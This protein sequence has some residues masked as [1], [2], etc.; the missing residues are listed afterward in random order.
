[1]SGT[2]KQ[3]IGIIGGMG[4]EAMVDLIEKMVSIPGADAREFIAFGNARLAY[5]PEEVMHKW[6]P[7]DPPELRKVDTAAFTLRLMQ[8]LGA[9]VMG[10]ACNSAHALFR[11]QLPA[12]PVAF[13]DMIHQT[14]HSLIGTLDNVLVMGVNS[15]VDSGLYQSALEAQGIASTKPSPD[16]QQKVMSA[17][18]DSAFGIK[19]AQI[20]RE[21][22]VLLCDVIRDECQQQGCSKVVLGCTE[23]PLALTAASCERFK[24]EGL[25]PEHIEVIDASRVLAESLLTAQGEGESLASDLETYRGPHSDW[26][27]PLTFK[28]SSFDMA[29][30]IQNEVLR[31]TVDFLAARGQ[32]VTGSYMHLPTL[33]ISESAQDAE[34][35]L[36]SMEMIVHTE[37]EALEPIIVDAL[38]RYYKDMNA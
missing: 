15:L 12:V 28:V 8:H 22:E 1:M 13:V 25:I 23:L 26:F 9:D 14:A 20:T 30:K 21:A 24:Q 2:H 19:T 27:A 31:L 4:N 11:R 16:N 34:E 3:R 37:D 6:L 17:I 38:E 36:Q 35:K 5:K 33:F 10:L 32:S 7:T 18:Y 29:A